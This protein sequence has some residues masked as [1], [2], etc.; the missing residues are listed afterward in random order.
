M[1]GKI[2]EASPTTIPVGQ[3]PIGVVLGK[4]ILTA[5]VTNQLSDTVS[6][7]D[8]FTHREVLTIPVGAGPR[9]AD[10]TED[11]KYLVVANNRGNSL[12]IIDTTINQVKATVAVGAG[13]L[14]PTIWEI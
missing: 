7:V 13:P 12:S 10:L 9:G 14:N 11:C 5:F 1:S 8:L 3:G 6:V 2:A 4:E